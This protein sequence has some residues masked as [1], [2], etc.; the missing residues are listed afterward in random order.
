MRPGGALFPVEPRSRDAAQEEALGRGWRGRRLAEEEV[1]A[2]QSRSLEAVLRLSAA[3][4]YHSG[5][6]QRHTRAQLCQELESWLRQMGSAITLE[7]SMS[8]EVAEA[9]SSELRAL[10]A[11]MREE[12][13]AQCG[14]IEHI[15]AERLRE[16][17]TGWLRERSRRRELE[18][19]LE[20]AKEADDEHRK[21]L[22]E[23]ESQVA[24]IRAQLEVE[25]EE[26]RRLRNE[27]RDALARLQECDRTAA[28]ARNAGGSDFVGPS[29]S[30]G[31]GFLS[32][33]SRLSI[34]LAELRSQTSV[35]RDRA[36]GQRENG[37]S[38][39]SQHVAEDLSCFMRELEIATRSDAVG[40]RACSYDGEPYEF[41]SAS[42]VPA[43][44]A[45]E[46]DRVADESFHQHW[47]GAR[48]LVQ[49]ASCFAHAR[50]GHDH[51]DCAVVSGAMALTEDDSA[52]VNHLQQRFVDEVLHLRTELNFAEAEHSRTREDLEVSEAKA[53]EARKESMAQRAVVERMSED[54]AHLGDR[55]QQSE[56]AQEEA[57]RRAAAVNAE[58]ISHFADEVAQLE[59]ELD[60][61]RALHVEMSEDRDAQAGAEARLQEALEKALSEREHAAEAHESLQQRCRCEVAALQRELA[62]ESAFASDR[63]R[64]RQELASVSALHAAALQERDALAR[65]QVGLEEAIEEQEL[66]EE[67]SRSERERL[68][69][70]LREV[71]AGEAAS[72][73]RAEALQREAW[74][75][76]EEVAHLERELALARGAGAEVA[77]HLDAAARLQEALEEAVSQRGQEERASA[78]SLEHLRGRLQSEERSEALAE[79]RVAEMRTELHRCRQGYAGEVAHLEEDLSSARAA[80]VAV[81]L[82][83]ERAERVAKSEF[84]DFRARFMRMEVAE[85]AAQDRAAAALG[86]LRQLG[87]S[88]THHHTG[89]GAQEVPCRRPM[90]PVS[91]PA[92]GELPTTRPGLRS[93]ARKDYFSASVELPPAVFRAAR[94][95]G[96][97][98]DEADRWSV[99]EGGQYPAQET[100]GTSPTCLG[101]HSHLGASED[102]RVRLSSGE[103]AGDEIG[104]EEKELPEW[105]RGTM[106]QIHADGW[107]A[108]QWKDGH[109]LLHWAAS[110]NKPELCSALI[111]FGAD[112]SAPNASGRSSIDIARE[113]QSREALDVLW[114]S[115]AARRGVDSQAGLAGVSE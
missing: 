28:G 5:P 64:L 77:R 62:E 115:S 67:S 50:Q 36:A 98:Q 9:Y 79:H 1:F 96:A 69:A 110:R 78:Q 101:S 30:C 10:K 32:R 100:P 112:P 25:R 7:R 56:A 81:V 42:L 63:E 111:R 93:K 15:A 85:A 27:H 91:N 75:R 19:L 2:Q 34:A 44:A 60:V 92:E 113:C 104:A 99:W 107:A 14:E 73:G 84:Q 21:R 53:Q 72:A 52:Q 22:R 89:L 47:E 8:S 20:R 37:S 109:T 45:G 24:A 6:E 46:E 61:A 40:R 80:E 12:C 54:M 38:C 41:E 16:F 76:S 94:V 87:A 59:R 105:V 31:P 58:S 57:E 90:H 70:R 74:Q 39:P 33:M 4:A 3:I 65:A 71:E 13:S 55:V 114:T 43:E 49:P 17:E 18:Q 68:R 102:D 83:H 86:H 66:A 35:Q 97:R 108:M 95:A 29:E 51:E 103:L 26:K 11:K 82:Q 88:V 106:R 23:H 48:E